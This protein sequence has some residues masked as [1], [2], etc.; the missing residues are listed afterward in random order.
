MEVAEHAA[1]VLRQVGGGDR[2]AQQ[3]ARAAAL[4]RGEPAVGLD[5]AIRIGT[6][7]QMISVPSP[8]DSAVTTQTN[9]RIP[10]GKEARR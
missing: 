6:P 2:L 9:V 5:S 10:I 4:E 7:I 3:P 1:A 8:T